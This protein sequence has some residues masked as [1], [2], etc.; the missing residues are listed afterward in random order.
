MVLTISVCLLV[1]INV[2]VAYLYTP[3]KA[4][5]QVDQYL[6][7]L[8]QR[9]AYAADS[10]IAG[11]DSQYIRQNLLEVMQQSENPLGEYGY[12]PGGVEFLHQPFDSRHI[13]VTTHYFNLPYRY[14]GADT[15]APYHIYCFGGST[16]FGLFVNDRHTWPAWLQQLLNETDTTGRYAVFNFGVSGFTPTQETALFHELLKHGHRPSLAIFMDGVNTG[17][18]YDG[19][20]YAAGIAQRFSYTGP[21]P[22]DVW[23]LLQQL[24]VVQLF[25]RYEPNRSYE[26]KSEEVFP[27]EYSTRYSTTLANR[28]TANAQQRQWLGQQYGVPILQFWQPNTYVEYNNEW[29]TAGARAVINDTVQ[30]NYRAITQQVLA[31]DSSFINLVPLFAQYGKPAVVDGLHYSPG[32]NRYLAQHI[33]PYVQPKVLKTYTFAPHQSSGVAFKPNEP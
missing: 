30:A 24:P 21:Q 3:P 14:S 27:V 31:A 9:D 18:I 2:L 1:L 23:P 16:T 25:K 7:Q 13:N 29:L 17:P 8:I 15:L 10:S 22:A 5:D 33:V 4:T 6:Q 20:E 26:G 28:F 32:F 12:Y 19:S 11:I